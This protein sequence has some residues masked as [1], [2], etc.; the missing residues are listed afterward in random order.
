[1]NH[2][3][4][5]YGVIGLMSVV[6]VVIIS[7]AQKSAMIPSTISNNPLQMATAYTQVVRPCSKVEKPLETPASHE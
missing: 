3:A 6:V 2:K 1:M 4:A 5:R 7:M